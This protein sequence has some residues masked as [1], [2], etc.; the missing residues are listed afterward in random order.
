MALFAAQVR[1]GYLEQGE[2]ADR[3]ED[4]PDAVHVRMVHSAFARPKPGERP[5]VV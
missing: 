4:H 2:G 5:V 3:D 1:G